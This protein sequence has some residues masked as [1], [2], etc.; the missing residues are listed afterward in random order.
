M[1]VLRLCLGI[2]FSA[3]LAMPLSASAVSL[4]DNIT[5]QDAL[6][7]T[8]SIASAGLFRQLK[9]PS[10]Y[11]EIWG[12]DAGIMVNGTFASKLKSVAEAHNKSFSLPMFPY[13]E[14]VARGGFPYGGSIDFGFF[15]TVGSNSFKFGAWSLAGRWAFAEFFD[16]PYITADVR[17]HYSRLSFKYQDVV[18]GV[19]SDISTVFQATGLTASVGYKMGGDWFAFEPYLGLGVAGLNGDLSANASVPGFF[20]AGLGSYN[21]WR[22]QFHMQLGADLKLGIFRWVLGYD[23]IGTVS[24]VSTFIG[25]AI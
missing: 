15:P 14:L 1:R 21:F 25:V 17:L 22:T 6:N 2:G 10:R 18:S 3:W 8:D 24:S 16:L 13:G 4:G 11:G 5:E 12:L 7:I 9:A 23:L 19:N 20:A